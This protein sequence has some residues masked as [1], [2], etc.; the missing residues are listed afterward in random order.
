MGGDF[1]DTFY[2]PIPGVLVVHL[3]R[4]VTPILPKEEVDLIAPQLSAHI[5]TRLDTVYACSPNLWG[6]GCK[7]ALAKLA[8][9]ADGSSHRGH[10]QP[11]IRQKALDLW[12]GFFVRNP[13]LDTL[14]QISQLSDALQHFGQGEWLTIPHTHETIPQAGPRAQAYGLFDPG[15]S[16]TAHHHSSEGAEP[17]AQSLTKEG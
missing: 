14:N 17:I 2:N 4:I 5:H 6:T 8:I 9:A 1:R 15:L 12:Q 3:K 13:K 10:A 11:R 16:W 7:C